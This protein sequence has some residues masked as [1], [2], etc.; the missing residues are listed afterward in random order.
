[1]EHRAEPASVCC[2]DK[3]GNIASDPLLDSYINAFGPSRALIHN[4]DRDALRIRMSK[5]KYAFN[6][7]RQFQRLRFDT[8]SVCRWL[9]DLDPVMEFDIKDALPLIWQF[10]WRSGGQS[11]RIKINDTSIMMIED[12]IRIVRS[13]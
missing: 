1:M 9:I 13:V 3:S 5:A 12:G 8:N 10:Y 2:R 4:D 7:I 6:A 11:V